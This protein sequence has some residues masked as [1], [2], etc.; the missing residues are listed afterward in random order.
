M[1]LVLDIGNTETTAGLFEEDRLAH[2]W[3]LSTARH[4][5]LDEWGALLL[6]IFRLNEIDMKEVRGVVVSSVVPPADTPLREM[7]RRYFGCEPLF[8]APGVKT[9]LNILYDNPSEVGADRVVKAVAAFKKYPTP[10][11]VVDFGTATTFDMLDVHGN[12][13]GGVIAP[14]V[15]ISAEALFERAAK[16]PKVE[17]AR[18]Q[19]VIGKSTVASMQSGVYWGYVSLVEGILAR[20]KREFGEVKTVVATGGFAAVMAD[21]CSLIDVVDETLTLEGLRIIYDRNQH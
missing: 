12:Y 20:M 13:I 1:I 19:R 14:G 7:S 17:I 18:P 11:I 2:C 6:S 9:S 21:D 5:T 15:G 8:I 10:A 4:R 16:L 3:R